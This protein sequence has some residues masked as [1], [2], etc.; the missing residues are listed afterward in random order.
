MRKLHYYFGE[1]YDAFVQ[2]RI[3]AINSDLSKNNLGLTSEKLSIL[4]EQ[5]SCVINCAAIV[6]HYGNYKDFEKINVI[7]VKKL[8]DFCKKYHKKLVQISTLS[9][10]G[11]TMFDFAMNQQKYDTNV[12]FNESNLY[13]GQSLENVYVRSKF[14]AEKIILTEVYQKKLDALILRIG[15]ITNRFSDGKFQQNASENAFANKI[16]AFMEIAALPDYVMDKYMEFS[17]VDC[18]AEAVIKAIEH[19]DTNVSVL[20]IYNPNHVYLKDFVQLL[21]PQYA[22]AVVQEKEFKNII[23]N[24]LKND[25]KR[26]IISNILNDLDS[27]RKLVYDTQINIQSKFSQNFLKQS[28]FTWPTITKEYIENLLKNL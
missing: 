10:S 27:E 2:K 21:P 20:H 13:I 16:K 3:I 8:V 22:L 7:A 15:N 25:E 18:V 4:N 28:N 26:Y 9:V 12:T 6:K 11:N 14:E 1:K 5:I 17:P 24:L 23:D 19:A